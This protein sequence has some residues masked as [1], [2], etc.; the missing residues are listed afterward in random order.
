MRVGFLFNH[1]AAHQVPQA[2]PYA[3]E[4]S[5]RHPEFKVIIAASTEAELDL[6]KSIESIYPGH[7][8]SLLRLHPAWWYTFFDR[9]V[10]KVTF[11]HKKSILR[12]NLDFFRNLDALVAPE[13]NC[14]L[15]RTRYGLNDLK[16]IHVRHGAGDREIA[17]DKYVA[18]FD[19]VL[20]PGQKYADRFNALG[21]LKP[22]H[23]AVTGWPKFEV[24]RA[25]KGEPRRF[26]DNNNPV[27]VYNPHFEQRVASWRMMGRA[28]L[29]FFAANPGYNLIFA[30]HVILFA[31]PW[32]HL[33]YLPR[34]YA[35]ALNILID[36]GSSRLSDMTYLLAADIYLGDVSS[37]VYEFLLEP[38]PCI[39]LN[40]H[41]IA[42]EDNPHYAH[43][44]FG[45]VV[46]D[47]AR[48]LGRALAMARQ[49]HAQFL[50]RQRAGF[51]HTFHIESGSTA[52]QRGADAIAG[53]LIGSVQRDPGLGVAKAP[54]SS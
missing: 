47:V 26:F 18:L 8:C 39:F 52:A 50:P 19:F 16:L 9:L 15:L 43:W 13:R 37:Q 27:V 45:Q 32:R 38:R 53:F 42:W 23:Y 44:H 17:T 12:N 46:D 36:T 11:E 35:K 25:L 54:A 40:A 3:Y 10:S 2:A 33:A 7:R 51:A 34:R 31:R 14:R 30:P 29:E 5:R 6:V 24:V 21:Y 20:L 28:V 22:G 49:S 1:Q 4:L 41:K 48:S